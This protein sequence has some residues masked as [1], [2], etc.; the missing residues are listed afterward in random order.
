MRRRRRRDTH[1]LVYCVPAECLHFSIFFFSPLIPSLYCS[2][3]LIL[4]S[5]PSL[6]RTPA[7]FYQW[8]SS[9][10]S[11]AAVCLSSSYVVSCP[12]NL[13]RSQPEILLCHSVG[14]LSASAAV[15]EKNYFWRRFGESLCCLAALIPDQPF[16]Y[17]AHTRLC[18]SSTCGADLGAGR[19]VVTCER[20][21]DIEAKW[22]NLQSA[23]TGCCYFF[24]DAL[25]SWSEHWVM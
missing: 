20:R 3:P 15:G 10:S 8:V 7:V 13:F 22:R 1:P 14:A 18:A 6:T 19:R 9:S 24:P 2:I 17:N 4:D 21:P 25:T 11:L 16:I 12:R 5:L 23:E